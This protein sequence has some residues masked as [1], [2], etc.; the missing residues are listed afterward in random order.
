MLLSDAILLAV[1]LGGVIVFLRITHTQENDAERKSPHGP[2][3]VIAW[4]LQEEVE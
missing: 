2:D 4:F 1:I 3:G